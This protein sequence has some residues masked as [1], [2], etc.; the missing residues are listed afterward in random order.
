MVWFSGFMGKCFLV[1]ISSS[2]VQ[3][4]I[5]SPGICFA[6]ALKTMCGYFTFPLLFPSSHFFLCFATVHIYLL[7]QDPRVVQNVLVQ[8]LS[9]SNWTFLCAKAVV[10]EWDGT[11]LLP[12]LE[13]LK[14]L[15]STAWTLW[16]QDNT[17]YSQGHRMGESRGSD[18]NSETGRLPAAFLQDQT[19]HAILCIFTFLQLCRILYW[20]MILWW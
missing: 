6:I 3:V 12:C 11:A 1:F 9:F 20:A 14:A 5:I 8:L 17:E 10:G 2:F 18:N 15:W 13:K 4:V 16:E 7:S 19:K